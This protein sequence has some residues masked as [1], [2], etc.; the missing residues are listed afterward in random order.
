[1]TETPDG[2]ILLNKPA[3][4]TS[5]QALRPI[6]S[7]L[8]KKSKVGHSGTLD[9]FATGLLA[10][11]VGRGTKLVPLFTAL[12]KRYE[13]TLRLGYESETLDPE[14]NPHKVG[15]PP[16]EEALSAAISLF[17][18]VQR[19]RPPV[20][21]AVHVAGE[22][23]YRRALR[24]EEVDL[25]ERQIEIHT[26]ELLSYDPPDARIAV[27]CSKGTYIRALARDIAAECGTK[28]YLTALERREIGPFDLAESKRE[29]TLEDLIP[30]EEAAG[31]LPGVLQVPVSEA[32]GR[33][34]RQGA[35][36]ATLLPPER[37][38]GS[39]PYRA[40]VEP[41]GRLSALSCAH[42]GGFGYI[43]VRP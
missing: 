9:Q 17:T 39:E 41:D 38:A 26:L 29:P 40:Y 1:M 36:A 31:R 10:V 32:E 42:E 6:K 27:S 2:L 20:Y 11:L 33:R 4:V 30:L 19:Q 37:L 43:L 5:F 13:G 16:T 21:S 34:I 24:G 28:A 12:D 25:P 15:Q 3:G 23:S 8:P 22:R 18:G 7:L 14:G 35:K